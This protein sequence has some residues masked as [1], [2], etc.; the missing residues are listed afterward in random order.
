MHMQIKQT[1]GMT[2]E[3]V[4]AGRAYVARVA[5][6]TGWDLTTLAK[7]AGVYSTTITRAMNDPK[8][9]FAFSG[10][11]LAKI[12]LASGI[13]LPPELGGS[14]PSQPPAK[15]EGSNTRGQKLSTSAQGGRGKGDKTHVFRGEYDGYVNVDSRREPAPDLAGGPR[16]LP[17]WGTAVCGEGERGDFRF[18]GEVVDYVRRPPRLSEV[19]RA[20]VV[21]AVGSSMEP[22][23]FPGD[24]AYIHPG[25]QARPGDVVLVELRS[26]REGEPGAAM[27]K[28][29]VS[30]TDSKIRLSQYNPADKR[31]ELDSR[32][33]RHIYRVVPYP[34]LLGL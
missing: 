22:R 32:K 24:P 28:V 21:Y 17:V 3:L 31:I 11:T 12:A 27:L 10:R 26:E 5:N 9:R 29:L 8:H 15:V 34:E 13:P 30:R 18:N 2:D 16:D 14:G 6:Q 19:K 1:A 23:Y 33:V 4:R 20:F 7:R 25:Q